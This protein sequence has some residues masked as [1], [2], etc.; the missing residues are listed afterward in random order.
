MN[1]GD[2]STALWTRFSSRAGNNI[3]DD[4]LMAYMR[5]CLTS[6]LHYKKFL[7]L[8]SFMDWWETIGS[9]KCDF[10]K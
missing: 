6:Q 10:C 5:T 3:A 4:P 8:V 1:E 7:M 9:T 2:F